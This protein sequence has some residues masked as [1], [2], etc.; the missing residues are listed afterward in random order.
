MLEGTPKE[1]LENAQDASI[2]AIDEGEPWADAAT[3][4]LVRRYVDALDDPLR[5]LHRARYIEGL[6]QR[7]AAD[8]L[9]ITRQVLRTLE[10]KLR[11]G[12]RSELARRQ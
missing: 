5:R 10:D 3:M 7:D 6:S 4:A 8:R 11:D 12:L 2:K 9:G 1:E